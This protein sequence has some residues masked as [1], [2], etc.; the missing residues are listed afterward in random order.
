MATVIV[1][2]NN[3][4]GQG[5][6]ELGQK[7]L[8]NCLRKLGAFNDLEAI[9]LYNAGVQL[10]AKDSPVAAELLLLYENGVD[11]L[12][13]GTCVEHY[14]LAGRLI[15]DRTSNMDDILALLRQAGKVM[16]L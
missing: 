15:V 16:T 6:A 13:C 1:L 5:D 2:N 11:L 14:G 3:Q 12:P 10:A 7:I 4:L 9:V 8:K